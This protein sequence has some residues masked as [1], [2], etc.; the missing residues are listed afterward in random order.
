ME[1][2]S[3]DKRQIRE[4]FLQIEDEVTSE[5]NQEEPGGQ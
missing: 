1:T 3:I 5:K 2:K 4:C